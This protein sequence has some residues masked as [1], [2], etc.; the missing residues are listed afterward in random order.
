MRD[1]GA[2]RIHELRGAY[3]PD[4]K[5]QTPRMTYLQIATLL[6]LTVGTVYNVATGRTHRDDVP[7]GHPLHPLTGT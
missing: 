7:L 6:G 1:E 5:K 4:G 2:A 3:T